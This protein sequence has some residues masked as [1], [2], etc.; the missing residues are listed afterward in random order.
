[1]TNVTLEKRVKEDAAIMEEFLYRDGEVPP[2]LFFHFPKINRKIASMMNKIPAG[3]LPVKNGFFLSLNDQILMDN[4]HEFMHHMGVIIA[5]MTLLKVLEAPESIVFCSEGWASSS[6]TPTPKVR[7]SKDPKAKD[8]FVISGRNSEGA[9]YIDIKEKLLKMVKVDGQKAIK[10]E[11]VPM[12]D[13]SAGEGMSPLLESFFES[14]T[15]HLK[16]MGEDKSYMTFSHQAAE[17]PVDAFRQGIEAA[18][19]MTKLSAL[20]RL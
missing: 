19:I 16:K 20:K 18:M 15:T 1:M 8:V 11:L 10:P 6:D 7:P 5:A 4:R 2:V 13:L 9:T 17:D 12:E 14:F 3:K